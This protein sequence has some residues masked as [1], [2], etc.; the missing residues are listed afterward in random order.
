M[1]IPFVGT[2]YRSRSLNMASQQCINLYPEVSEV[3]G[4]VM[5]LYGTPGLRRLV[6]IPGSGGIRGMYVPATGRAIVVRGNRVYRLDG[7]WNYQQCP[8]ELLTSSGTVCITDNGTTAVIVDGKYGYTLDLASSVVSRITS[9][10]FYGADRVGFIDGY[11]IFNKPDTQQFYISSLYGTDFDGLDF[12]SAEGSP[13]L[14]VSLIVDHREVWMFGDTSTEVFY[15]SGNPDFPIERIQGAFIEHGCAAPHSVAKLD[16]TVFWVGKDSNG[17]GTVW[18]AN[19][20]TPQRISTHP[21]E[22]A[23][24]SYGQISDAIAYTYQQDGHAFYVLTFP[25]ASKTWVYDAATQAWHE[26]AWRNTSTGNFERHRSNCLIYF[27]GK[28]ICGDWEDGRIYQ[29]DPDYYTDDGDPLVALRAAPVVSN[30]PKR[31]IHQCLTIEIEEGVGLQIQEDTGNYSAEAQAIFDR[32]DTPP[33]IDVKAAIDTFITALQDAGVWDKLDALQVYAAENVQASLL[34]WKRDTISGIAQESGNT[35]T[36]LS[37][38]SSL[39][40]TAF[41]AVELNYNPS[42]DGVLYTQD[43]CSIGVY[44]SGAITEA[45]SVIACADGTYETSCG[46][47]GTDTITATVNNIAVLSGS[48]YTTPLNGLW[49]LSRDA[50]GRYLWIG[51]AVK[52]TDSA[53]S[54]AVPNEAVTFGNLTGSSMTAQMAFAGSYLNSTE[55]AALITAF[56]TYLAAI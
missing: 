55:T 46:F 26:R 40:L 4:S 10:A 49:M 22:Y 11:F 21:I 2:A 34:D 24:Q 35:F 19:G 23:L 1:K 25:Q 28:H 17:S 48:P 14:L 16:N 13:D 43:D 30:Q 52:A 42:T 31:L 47:N 50:S 41:P 6:T 12:A 56:E 8:G 54:D 53:A 9:D 51:D 36:A 18:R 32:M 5:A 45:M 15:N 20:Y 37:G 44:V 3:D 38:Y 7:K 27:G 33:S 29:L 39:N